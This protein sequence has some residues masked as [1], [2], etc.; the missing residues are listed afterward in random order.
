MVPRPSP[1]ANREMKNH[2]VRVAILFMC[3]ASII[4]T[5][6]VLP[7]A[8][9][10]DSSPHKVSF[11]EVQ[12]GVRLEVLD[13]GGPGKPVLLLAGDGDTAHVFDDF[14]PLL[15]RH[16]RV[17]GITRRGFGA[18]S[19]PQNGYDLAR[20]VEDI[21]NVADALNIRQFDIIGHSIAGDEMNRLAEMFPGRVR[22]L[23]YL[24]AAY[25]RVE[26]EHMEAGFHLPHPLDE[27]TSTDLSSPEALTAYIRKTECPG[28]PEAEVRAT[29]VFGP[30]GRFIRAITPDTILVK[31]AAV[32]EHPQYE[33]IRA[34]A[35]A[36]YAVKKTPAQMFPVYESSDAE[37]QVALKAIFASESSFQKRQ[38][39]QF[40]RGMKNG[41]AIQ[42][43]G[44]NHYVF[45][46]NPREV[47]RALD[48]FL[49]PQ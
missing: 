4:V 45:I 27:P 22:Q 38:R 29:R 21:V 44:A 35:L 14:A 24:D 41:R 28:F 30:D 25:D 39:E 48:S 8:N 12:P 33:K 7:A 5:A 42:I 31:V 40:L 47:L 46:S 1:T 16:Y 49:S 23:V 3:V 6:T 11:V 26:S 20:L 13:W 37:T 18:S 9:W 34:P 17:F 19:Q 43:V 10:S 32:V 2:M 15:A 36:V